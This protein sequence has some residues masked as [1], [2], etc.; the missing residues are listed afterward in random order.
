MKQIYFLSIFLSFSGLV[1]SQN[2]SPTLIDSLKNE[3]N[4]A[5]LTIRYSEKQAGLLQHLLVAKEMALRSLDLKDS[6]FQALLA[7]QAYRF[8][9]DNGGSDYDIDIFNALYSALKKFRDPL[10]KTLSPN[11]DLRDKKIKS[12][13][14]SMAEK[15]CSYMQRNML[16]SEWN[17]FSSHLPY[18]VT[19]PLNNR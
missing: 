13:T 5:N 17:R 12:K 11:L 19:C 3:I 14:K 2:M 16:L 18:E 6:I 9:I 1:S 15:L 10:A 8:Q 7:V 4:K